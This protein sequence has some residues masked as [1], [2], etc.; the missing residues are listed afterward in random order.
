VRHNE[1]NQL[2]LWWF[3]KSAKYM[4]PLSLKDIIDFNLE[5]RQIYWKY[6][7]MSEF[8]RKF[9]LFTWYVP[10]L[11]LDAQYR[12]LYL[13]RWLTCPAKILDWWDNQ[14]FYPKGLPMLCSWN[15]NS[16]FVLQSWTCLLI[17]GENFELMEDVQRYVYVYSLYVA[18]SSVKLVSARLIL[19]YFI[20]CSVLEMLLFV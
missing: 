4:S 17:T 7:E 15:W 18:N 1:D 20:Q 3:H 12:N 2:L 5:I 10:F 9:I 14:R 8:S 11:H 6:L 13:Y 16:V 19:Y